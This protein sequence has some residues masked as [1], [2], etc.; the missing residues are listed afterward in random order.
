MAD[1]QCVNPVCQRTNSDTRTFCSNCGWRLPKSGPPHDGAGLQEAYDQL[2]QKY[3]QL[4][5]RQD[6]LQGEHEQLQGQHEQLASNHAQLQGKA[7]QLNLS[8]QSLAQEHQQTVVALAEAQA[9]ATQS[10]TLKQKAESRIES[11]LEELKKI[12]PGSGTSPAA[13]PE[14][15]AEIVR[16]NQLLAQ[17]QHDYTGVAAQYAEADAKI[18]AFESS[19]L[20]KLIWPLRSRIISWV[21]VAVAGLISGGA[22]GI[23]TPLNPVKKQLN[24]IVSGQ[25]QQRNDLANTSTQLSQTAQ[26]L[27]KAKQDLAAQAQ[28]NSQLTTQLDASKQ[29]AQ[30][31]AEQLSAVKAQLAESKGEAAK[32][33]A[34][35]VE[36]QKQLEAEKTR[37]QQLSVKSALASALQ[38]TIAAHPYLTY[39]G[40]N[41]GTITIQYNGKNDKPANITLDHLNSSSESGV[42]VDS[43]AGAQL[44][45]VPVVVEP[46]SKNVSILSPPNSANG[47]QKMTIIVQGKNSNKAVLRWTVF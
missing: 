27:D 12:T 41:Q 43:V 10:E 33:H 28:T 45:G 7:E 38:A 6:Q 26:D 25:G 36:T 16:L 21:L 32:E 42:K 30:S 14:A 4:A 3:D 18:K 24:M 17:A 35:A 22:A 8:H 37:S 15:Q 46:M 5:S 23:Y 31:T 44:P 20:G 2:Q 11:L 29:S 39:R 34:A 1:I 19:E 13:S 9:L 40:P 47:W